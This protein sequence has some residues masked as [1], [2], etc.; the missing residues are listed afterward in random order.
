[1]KNSKIKRTNQ[2]AANKINQTKAS[3]RTKI[4]KASKLV[5]EGPSKK[6]KKR[7][8]QSKERK[9]RSCS[10]KKGLKSKSN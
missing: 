8:R 10:K 3:Q 6:S 1:M 5:S 9:S 2:T 7:D 4:M